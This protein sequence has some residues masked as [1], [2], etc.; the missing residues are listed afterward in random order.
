MSRIILVANHPNDRRES[1]DRYVE[2]LSRE[3]MAQNFIVEVLRPDQSFVWLAKRHA[4][5]GKWMAYADKFFRFPR[6]LRRYVSKLLK[7]GD[8]FVVHICDQGDAVYVPAVQN[9]PHVVTC[10]DLIAIRSA[11]GE[12]PQQRTRITGR[13][14]QRFILAGLRR[15]TNVICVSDTTRFDFERVVEAGQRKVIVIKNPLNHPYHPMSQDQAIPLLDAVFHR[16]GRSRPGCY[17]FHVGGNQWYK[18]RV[19]L[20]RIYH[21]LCSMGQ[22]PFLVLAGQP[23]S[24]EVLSL[25]SELQL[26]GKVLYVGKVSNEELN[27]FYSQAEALV[28]PS[29]IEG[30]GWPVIE[31]Q[32][33]GCPVIASD[34][35]IF[36]EIG[37]D[38]VC[39]INPDDSGKAAG[40]IYSWLQSIKSDGKRTDLIKRGCENVANYSIERV[41][42]GYL[43]AYRECS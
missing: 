11:L 31:G 21:A 14:Y 12:L 38:S 3:L 20:I 24:N 19:G 6:Y 30:F 9:V 15:A 41:M 25:I 16:F 42:P 32:A 27:A 4:G 8:S 1:M 40:T 22:I 18:N 37:G 33:V 35:P 28:F 17:L 43:Q 13:I 26:V 2:L 39:F 5:L 23:L 34:I 29:L 10:H 7:S 36:R